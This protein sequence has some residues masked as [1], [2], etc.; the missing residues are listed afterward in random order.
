MSFKE[1]FIKKM[2]DSWPDI[3]RSVTNFFDFLT[4]FSYLLTIASFVAVCAALVSEH[5]SVFWLLIPLVVFAVGTLFRF[6][7]FSI[8]TRLEYTRY[9]ERVK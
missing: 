1:Y 2:Q 8:N 7:R 6:I 3:L 4:F 9:V 5:I